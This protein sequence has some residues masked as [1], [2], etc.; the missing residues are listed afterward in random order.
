[1]AF[2]A[3]FIAYNVLGYAAFA[4]DYRLRRNDLDY[5][6]ISALLAW[7][8]L[9]AMSLMVVGLVGAF[10]WRAMTSLF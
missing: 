2:L 8:V 7:P 5:N 3:F 10:V 6:V 9:S 1:M 4:I